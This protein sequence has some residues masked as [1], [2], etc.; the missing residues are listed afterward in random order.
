MRSALLN[1]SV[2]PELADPARPSTTQADAA[3]ISWI[4]PVIPGDH[5]DPSII[6]VGQHLWAAA[7]SGEWSPQFPLF[8]ST[9]L[10]HWVPAGAIFFDQPRWAEGSFWAPELTHDRGRLICYYVARQRGGPLSIAVATATRPGGRWTDHGPILNEPEGSIDPCFA[11]DEHGQPF[12]IW[13]TDGN[14][15]G[16]P[17]PIHAQPLTP[18][19]LHLTGAPVQ[20]ITNDAPWEAGVVEGPSILRHS[21]RFY[22]FYAGN[23]CCGHACQ[24]AEGVARA[25]HLLG[26]W[27]KFPHNP[28]I[29]AND[30]WRC[31]GH[32]TAVHGLAGQDYL[33]YHAYPAGGTIYVGRE[34]V[35]DHIRWSEDGWPVIN[36]GRGPGHSSVNPPIDFRDRFTA[37]H[38]GASWQW[39]VNTH[40]S[41][42][43]GDG[44]LCLRVPKAGQ[45]AMVAIPAPGLPDYTC[46]VTLLVPAEA[47]A[48]SLPSPG[49]TAGSAAS[50]WA[51]LAVVGDPF[52]TIGL[53]LRGR[54]LQ[55]WRRGGAEA[56]VI[57]SAPLPEAAR[58]LQLQVTSGGQAQLR[59]AFTVDGGPP[60]PAGAPV[61]ASRLPA[62]DRGLRLGL[63][64][65]APAGTEVVF[66]DFHLHTL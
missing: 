25:S 50:G 40:P 2:D 45:S 57:W 59:F 52:N 3:P 51:G 20:L 16:R 26:P 28:L 43:T 39:P 24:Y 46:S 64:I 38:L 27:E 62:W 55:L 34:A 42:A 8:H 13:K 44:Q 53:G 23:T 14:S 36:A 21:H 4:N 37:P 48:T 12:L 11:R 15:V 49:P 17:T 29:D 54:T 10:V 35:L 33:L 18:D 1:L 19:L 31:P 66:S 56:S 22:M 41:L 9:D 32:G 6:R 65:E 7:T 47:A 63:M 30:H 60:E 58:S 5:P 61:D